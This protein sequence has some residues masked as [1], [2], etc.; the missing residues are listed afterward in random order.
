MYAN[1]QIHN[2]RYVRNLCAY[3]FLVSKNLVQYNKQ[4]S[5]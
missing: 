5:K 1:M 3:V 4:V 2:R